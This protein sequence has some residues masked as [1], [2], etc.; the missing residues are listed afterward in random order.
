MLTEKAL[1]IINTVT[2]RLKLALALGVGEQTIIRY[3]SVNHENLTKA[4]A[5]KVIR[6]QTGLSDDEIIVEAKVMA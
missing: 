5:L 1:L 6:E 2:I 4:A 3:I